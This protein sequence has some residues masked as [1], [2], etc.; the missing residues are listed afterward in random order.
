VGECRA[1]DVQDV[2][3]RTLSQDVTVLVYLWAMPCVVSPIS[4]FPLESTYIQDAKFLL[5]ELYIVMNHFQQLSP[6]MRLGNSKYK[7]SRIVAD[8]LA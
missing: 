4:Y 1:F 5:I 6:T 8:A 3:V 7:L 2:L